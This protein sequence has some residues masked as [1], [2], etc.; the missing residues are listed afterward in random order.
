VTEDASS[1]RV[2]FDGIMNDGNEIKGDQLPAQGWLGRSFPADPKMDH[3]SVKVASKEKWIFSYFDKGNK[4]TSKRIVT[5]DGKATEAKWY[6]GDKL[7][8]NEVSEIQ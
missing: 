5:T 8:E 3:V 4:L 2:R 7:L 6:V 1:H